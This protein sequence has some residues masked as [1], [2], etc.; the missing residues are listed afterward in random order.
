M[1]AQPVGV[2]LMNFL[3][4][5]TLGEQGVHGF[6]RVL[7]S[8]ALDEDPAVFVF[9]AE[10]RDVDVHREDVFVALLRDD[11]F[12]LVVFGQLDHDLFLAQVVGREVD[13]AG[14]VLVDDADDVFHALVLGDSRRT[15]L[16]NWKIGSQ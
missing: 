3:L 6:F 7:V 2:I 11:H 4:R 16:G 8:P 5:E 9:G 1:F 12:G 15:R 14:L 10:L 13:V